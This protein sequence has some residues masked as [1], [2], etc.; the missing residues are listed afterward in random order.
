MTAP[1]NIIANSSRAGPAKPEG[2]ARYRTRASMLVRSPDELK[3]LIGRAA[4]KLA[5]APEKFAAARDQ[6]ISFLG[7]LKAYVRGDYRDVSAGSLIA[8]V[9]AVLYFVVPLDLIPDFLLGLGLLDDAAVI[10]YVFSIVQ[11]EVSHFEDWSL[12]Q[13]SVAPK[14]AAQK[15]R[16]S[17]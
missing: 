1:R 7:L 6:L 14:P 17:P 3:A 12:A 10:G 8:I 16:T 2:F 4:R 15:D 5:T 9:S 13:T 11:A